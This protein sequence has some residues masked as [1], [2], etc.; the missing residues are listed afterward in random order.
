[1]I[2]LT[3]HKVPNELF[4]LVSFHP[5]VI[6]VV[7]LLIVYF[8]NLLKTK[9]IYTK[10]QNCS[11]I[12]V[13]LKKFVHHFNSKI[14]FMFFLKSFLNI[15]QFCTHNLNLF[16]K[17]FYWGYYSF[18]IRSYHKI[19]WEI[20]KQKRHMSRIKKIKK[21]LKHKTHPEILINCIFVVEKN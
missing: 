18:Q 17:D 7:T 15:W 19:I 16:K 10:M 4:V 1:M 6:N 3:V 2:D 5:T 9:K 8:C 11:T 13:L 14:N 20:L 12:T 21:V